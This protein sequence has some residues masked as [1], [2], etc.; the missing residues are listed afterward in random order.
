[1]QTN[2]ADTNVLQYLLFQGT[3]R[4]YERLSVLGEGD[5]GT[6][7][8]GKDCRTGELC[9]IKTPKGADGLAFLRQEAEALSRL[10]HPKIIN[11]KEALESPAPVLVLE[12]FPAASLA[13]VFSSSGH[14]PEAQ[15]RFIGQEVRDA[16]SYVHDQKVIHLDVKPENI[17]VSGQAIKLGDFGCATV[18]K[19]DYVFYYGRQT[20]G[21]ES[22]EQIATRR[23]T[24]ASDLY[25]LGVTL[26]GCCQ[27]TS[28]ITE[29]FT[30]PL[31]R[32]S[33]DLAGIIS[34]LLSENPT[35]RV[36]AAKRL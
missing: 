12:Y 17:L 35:D 30:K 36:E 2:T 13:D 5:C 29:I 25:A 31:P 14:L 27:G 3:S 19:G 8:L 26:L 15:T 11:L 1:M 34:G 20:P 4:Q 6:V 24:P 9:A 16:L 22:P 7:Y 21:Y 28:D 10:R 23:V 18:M 32:I 33:A